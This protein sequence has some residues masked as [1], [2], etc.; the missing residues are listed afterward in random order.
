M[1]FVLPAL[2]FAP[3][4]D[5]DVEAVAHIE[6]LCFADPW[7]ERA[8]R[9]ELR[10]PNASLWVARAPEV[11]GYGVM[12][13]QVDEAH[14]ANLAVHPQ[15]RRRGIGRGLLRALLLE[16]QQRRAALV[17]LEVRVSNIAA[18]RL[19]AA[20][21]FEVVGYRKAYYTNNREDALIMTVTTF[22]T[23]E[24]RAQLASWAAEL[25]LR[26]L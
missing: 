2:Y 11:V 22:S 6:R 8:F 26:A 25:P 24:Y 23:P 18:Q 15:H 16:A 5:E 9:D 1:S 12:W 7:P 10:K 3:M 14:I 19:Y 4:R 21:G 20:H 17:T 13:M